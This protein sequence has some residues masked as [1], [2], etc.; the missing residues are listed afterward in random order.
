[1]ELELK[2]PPPIVWLLCAGLMRVVSRVAGPLSFSLPA[3]LAASLMALLAV[4]GLAVG[5]MGLYAFH[6][7]RTTIHPRHP[8][9]ATTLVTHGIYRYTRNPM[10]LGMT[11]LLLAWAVY[12]SNGA[13]WLGVALFVA[14]ITRF[15]IVPE[16]RVLR[17]LFKEE[18]EAY[19]RSVRRWL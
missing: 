18:Y 15:Q 8:D 2:V 17:Q 16:E 4:S 9:R 3:P 10:Y 13:A 1:M 14:Y 11:L 7:A 12:L 6:R 19:S 5:A